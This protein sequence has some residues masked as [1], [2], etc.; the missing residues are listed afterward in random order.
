MGKPKQLLTFEGETLLSRAARTAL[1]TDCRPVIVVLGS[2]ADDL[3]EEIAALDTSIVVNQLWHEGM[4]SSIRCGLQALEATAPDGTEAV[5]SML[6]DQP[7]VTSK[8]IRRLG[9]AYR[10][11][12]ALLV[13][14]EYETDGEKTFGVPA[15]FS[16][17]LF[18]ELRALNGAEGAKR[19]ITRHAAEAASVAMPEASF[20][21]DTPDDYRALH[22]KEL[23]DR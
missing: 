13:A 5:I 1:E 12:R 19:I 20:D 8:V 2:H 14:S 23:F 3:Q 18:P 4:G 16:R 22:N 11:S 21:V 7:F 6:C 17:A 9:D 10:A 15:L